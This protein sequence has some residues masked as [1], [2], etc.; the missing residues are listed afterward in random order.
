MSLFQEPRSEKRIFKSAAQSG[1]FPSKGPNT[2][3]RQVNA[4]KLLEQEAAVNIAKRRRA[5]AQERSNMETEL[6]RLRM[7]QMSQRQPGL[8][9]VANRIAEV[10]RVVQQVDGL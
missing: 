3:T 2:L 10:E 5:V 8:R 6:H 7:V 9:G 4:L 1:L